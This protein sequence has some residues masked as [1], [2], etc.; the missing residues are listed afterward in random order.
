[1][2]PYEVHPGSAPPG[3]LPV[4]EVVRDLFLALIPL[5]LFTA[6]SA[7]VMGGPA[8]GPTGGEARRVVGLSAA[9]YGALALLILV[10]APRH[11][12]RST[13]ASGAQ[14]LTGDGSWGGMGPANR[15]TLLRA[16][17]VVPLAALLPMWRELESGGLWWVI[18]ISTLVLL[19]DGVDGWVARKTHSAT[20]FG[21]RFDMELDA[22]LLLVLSLGVWLSGKVGAWVILIGALRYL[23]VVAGWMWPALQEPLPESFRRK[24]A[25]VVQGIALL[26]CLGP[27]IPVWLAWAAAAFSLTLLVYSFGADILW[28]LRKR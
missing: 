11:L 23:F 6:G 22:F 9:L 17:M 27:I 14:E 10:Q 12:N 8:G 20:A 18:G 28:L 25:C 2:N 26:V 3:A 4:G 5:A 21:A 1:M 7:W 13:P 15:I 19:L 16:T 24:A